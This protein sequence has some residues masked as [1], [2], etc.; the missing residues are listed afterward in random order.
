L[1]N[2]ALL[3][4]GWLLSAT[5][6]AAAPHQGDPSFRDWDLA[7]AE[8]REKNLPIAI[9]FVAD[10]CGFCERLQETFLDPLKRDGTLSDRAL[11]HSFDINATGK[12]TD[13]DGERLRTPHFVRRYGVFATPT[14]VL[15]SPDGTLLGDPLVGFN[16]PEEYS[17]LFDTALAG[18]L[19]LMRSPE[20]LKQAVASQE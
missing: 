5:A 1:K 9:V 16:S 6:L 19:T 8:A 3:L 14:I 13:F 7:S 10:H 15:V 4:F 20:G 12:V 11:V 18:A 17:G 2:L